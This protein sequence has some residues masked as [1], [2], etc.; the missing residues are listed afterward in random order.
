MVASTLDNLLTCLTIGVYIGSFIFSFMTY[1]L[2]PISEK[3]IERIGR[4]RDES[5][6]KIQSKVIW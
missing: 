1:Y 3:K 2:A 6:D 4:N 5:A